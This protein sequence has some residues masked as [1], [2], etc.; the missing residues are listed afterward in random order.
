MIKLNGELSVFSRFPNNETKVG[1][2]LN[3]MIKNKAFFKYE[4]DQDLFNLMLLKKYLDAN[5]NR[6][7]RSELIISYMPYSRMDRSEDDSPFT[8][9][10]VADFINDLKFDKVTVVEPHSDVTPA[11]LNNVKVKFVT[12]DLIDSVKKDVGFDDENDCLMFPDAGATKRYSVG[13]GVNVV[14]GNKKRDF[15]TGEIT[16]FEL[17]GDVNAAGKKVIIVDDMSSFG[18]TF[19]KAAKALREQGFTEIYLLVAHAEN[20]IFAGSLFD[21]ID[22]IFT[23]DSLLTEQDHW[24]NKKFKSQLKIFSLEE[25]LN[26]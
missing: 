7:S 12:P 19:V 13:E 10:Y 1:K 8:L 11:L 15:K 9:K 18:G 21:N 4:D 20:S 6:F 17:Y 24:Q 25:L 3:S 2:I 5:D 22:K 23:T 16:H 14:Y 26:V